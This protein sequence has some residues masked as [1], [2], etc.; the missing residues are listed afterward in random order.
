MINN[1]GFMDRGGGSDCFWEVP[2][3]RPSAVYRAVEY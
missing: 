1:L 2:C 3:A